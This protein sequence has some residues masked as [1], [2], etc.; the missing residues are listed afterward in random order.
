M[1]TGPS[2]RL[3]ARGSLVRTARAAGLESLPIAMG[4]ASLLGWAFGTEQLKAGFPGD[5]PMKVNTA[6]LMLVTGLGLWLV[7][8]HPSGRAPAR[9]ASRSGQLRWRSRWPS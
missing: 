5:S 4:A 9:P 6:V 1:T 2:H 8:H 3:P 7:R